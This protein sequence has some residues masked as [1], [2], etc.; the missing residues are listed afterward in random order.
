MNWTRNDKG[1]TAEMRLATI[2]LALG[3]ALLATACNNHSEEKREADQRAA[4]AGFV[5]PSV[6][7]RVDFG[8]MMDRRFRTLDRDGNDIITDNEMPSGNSRIRELDRNGDGEVTHSE[9]SEGTLNWFDRMD[10][11]RDGA[12]TSEERESSRTERPTT[13]TNPVALNNAN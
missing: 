2:G 4:A 10:L 6:T 9:F 11:N 13:P 1:S 5:P 12:V 3:T 7:S 8:G